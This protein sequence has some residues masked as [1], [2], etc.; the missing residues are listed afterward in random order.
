ME[1]P[2][3]FEEVWDEVLRKYFPYKLKDAVNLAFTMGKTSGILSTSAITAD[4]FD[5]LG[6]SSASH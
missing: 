6:V 4:L 1:K 2:K 3:E 5:Q